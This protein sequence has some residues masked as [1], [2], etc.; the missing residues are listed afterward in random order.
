MKSIAENSDFENISPVDILKTEKDIQQEQKE[1]GIELLSVQDQIKE[2]N[3]KIP[4]GNRKEKAILEE[5]KEMLVEIESLLQSKFE[6]NASHLSFIDE[7]KKKDAEEG[8][9][10]N[11]IETQQI[12]RASCRERV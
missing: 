1:I 9:D 10:K 6:E 8:I 11:A 3:A 7:Q 12:G 2:I 4:N 5:N